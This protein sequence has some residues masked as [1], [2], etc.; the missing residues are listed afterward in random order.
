MVK[1]SRLT[2]LDWLTGE[3]IVMQ[4]ARHALFPS[5]VEYIAGEPIV[6]SWWGHPKGHEIFRALTAVYESPDVVATKLVAGKVTL[7]H[8]R[9]WAAVAALAF[10]HS[11]RARSLDRVTQEHTAAGR[12]ENRVVPFPEWLPRGLKLPSVEQAVQ[13]LGAQRAA[14]LCQSD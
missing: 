10:N 5:L 6:G 7:I 3:G 8:R 12:H 9:L 2:P 14:A 4:S 13:R 11:F 1:R